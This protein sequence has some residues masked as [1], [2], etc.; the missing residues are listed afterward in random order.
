MKARNQLDYF[1]QT[2]LSTIIA[3]GNGVDQKSNILLAVNFVVLGFLGE[4][5]KSDPHEW[6]LYVGILFF[7]SSAVFSL[8]AVMPRIHPSVSALGLRKPNHELERNLIAFETVSKLRLPE[9]EKE[10]LAT[11]RSEQAVY[12]ITLKS[13]HQISRVVSQKF[14]MARI[15]YQFLFAGIVLYVL[16]T[17][18]QHR[19]AALL[20]P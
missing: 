18:I 19:G 13:I 1:L 4:K 8:L 3:Q 11:V 2:A 20:S 14:R 10:M 16:C 5:I 6:A 9:Y 15:S 7:L 17:L 12:L